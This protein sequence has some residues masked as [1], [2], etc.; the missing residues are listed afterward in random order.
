MLS[1]NRQSERKIALHNT[2]NAYNANAAAASNIPPFMP[3]SRPLKVTA[4][5][6][7]EC[8]AELRSHSH[9]DTLAR[10]SNARSQDIWDMMPSSPRSSAEYRHPAS[11]GGKAYVD[12][13]L[14]KGD[15][16]RRPKRTLEWACAA[17]RLNPKSS[18]EDAAW[19]NQGRQSQSGFPHHDTRRAE[20]ISNAQEVAVGDDVLQ[21][22][23]TLCG[24]KG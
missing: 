6:S 1:E 2:T 22:A 21:A 7:L 20:R 12:Y 19:G 13:V 8:V 3:T 17:A 24:L 5:V 14:S 23:M 10:P 9:K 15:H 4:G 11:P 16:S 18:M